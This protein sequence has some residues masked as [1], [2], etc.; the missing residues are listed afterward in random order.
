MSE[1]KRKLVT[2]RKIDDLQPIEGADLIEVA[3]I[4]GWKVV[5]K[6]GEF[7]VGDKCVYFEID[8]FLPAGDYPWKFLV[9]KSSRTFNGVVGHKLRTVKLRGVVSQGFVL[10]L[11]A[12]P[13]VQYVIDEDLPG[14]PNNGGDVWLS[15]SEME[16]AI[17]VLNI[18]EL[19]KNND[20]RA[21]DLSDLLGIVKFD[22]P[23][24]AELA[25]Q[26]QG[27]FPSFIRKTDQERV[28]NLKQEVFGYDSSETE[29][30]YSLLSQDVL[31]KGVEEGRMKRRED[32]SYV[33]LHTAKASRDARYEVTMKLDGSSMTAFV[34]DLNGEMEVGVCSR[35]LQLK[36]NDENADN[37]FVKMVK[38]SGL[39]DA[40]A[41][42]HQ[43]TGRSVAIQGELMGPGIQGNR[44]GLAKHEFYVFDI[45]DID[46]GRYLNPGERSGVFTWFAGVTWDNGGKDMFKHVPILDQS[47]NL[48]EAGLN[49]IED[50]LKFAEGPSIKHKVR[51]GLVFKR[52]DGQFSFKAI[53]N[54]FLI[55]EKE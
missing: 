11:S 19:R 39:Y 46:E 1:N 9:D 38:N 35:N 6:K 31:D 22:P 8:S 43:E 23:L 17:A 14:Q 30:N 27:M 4:E 12:L 28:Q 32:G 21:L 13:I 25:G 5:V 29:F 24:P 20:I 34:H 48:I 50:V 49:T 44:E 41:L 55:G 36:I 42:F 45:F 52:L 54:K 26:A 2:V 40:L 18:E 10:P 7:H 51:E 53:S 3:S 16:R 37:T 47:M 33:L 15:M